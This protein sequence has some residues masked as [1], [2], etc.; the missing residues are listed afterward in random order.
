MYQGIIKVI[1]RRLA[2]QSEMVKL[3]E[4]R[5]RECSPGT[6]ETCWEPRRTK[7]LV[8]EE[9]TASRLVTFAV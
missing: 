2:L 8:C 7:E 1:C 4:D 5:K 6:S 3:F 9:V